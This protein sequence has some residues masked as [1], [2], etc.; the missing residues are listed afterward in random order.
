MCHQRADSSSGN[1]GDVVTESVTL[2]NGDD[3]IPCFKARPGSPGPHPGVVV[4]HDIWGANDFYQDLCRRLACA[5]YSAILPDLF[6]RQDALE[7]QDIQHARER[8]LGMSEPVALED[9]EV[10]ARHLA[11]SD[12]AG[13]SIGSMGFCMGGTLVLLWAAQ[14]D[15]VGGCLLLWVPR[16][17]GNGECSHKRHGC[18]LGD[19]SAHNRFLGRWRQE[20]GHRERGAS[21]RGV[22]ERGDRA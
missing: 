10:S 1:W 15:M 17:P 4:I 14:S 7:E 12:S 22:R 16:A 2:S 6:S 3:S 18:R 19:Q 20:R 11:E 5:G 21:A 8:R 13:R 9:L